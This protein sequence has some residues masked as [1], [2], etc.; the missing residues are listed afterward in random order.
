M[1]SALYIYV[2]SFIQKPSIWRMGFSSNNEYR[3]VVAVVRSRWAVGWMT[4]AQTRRSIKSLVD[5]EQSQWKHR[6]RERQFPLGP[7]QETHTEWWSRKAG[8]EKK[9]RFIIRLALRDDRKPPSAV[10]ASFSTYKEMQSSWAASSSF[11]RLSCCLLMADATFRQSGR[12]SYSCRWSRAAGH[13]NV[14]VN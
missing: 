2:S 4:A 10:N 7:T 11:E 14:A 6:E 12:P 3:V 13:L 1:T 9:L 5:D 8:R